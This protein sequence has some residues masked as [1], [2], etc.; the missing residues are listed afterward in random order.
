MRASDLLGRE[1]RASDGALLGRVHD[2]RLVVGPG[3][4]APLRLTSLIVG[5]RRSFIRL[6]YERRAQQGP[7]LLRVLAGYW[8]RDTRIVPWTAVHTDG[9]RLVVTGDPASMLI[10]S[11]RERK[12]R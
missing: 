11:M 8:L 5:P 7:W 12:P 9:E 10:R 1:V 6:G 2:V 4:T 3:G